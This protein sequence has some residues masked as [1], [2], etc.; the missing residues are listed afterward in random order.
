[1]L[2][3]MLSP[4]AAVAP[5]RVLYLE[6]DTIAAL[7]FIRAFG[8]KVTITAL[9]DPKE[10][11]ENLQRG[12]ETD[13]IVINEN[14]G[15]LAFLD[16]LRANLFLRSIPVILV[17]SYVTDQ[18]KRQAQRRQ[19]LDVLSMDEAEE[20]IRVRIE[21]LIRRREYNFTKHPPVWHATVRL[22]IGKRAFDI[23]VSLG[24]LLFLS[25]LLLLVAILIKL[26]SPGPVL[27]RSK[28]VG[29]GFKVFDMLKFRTMRTDADKMLAGMAAYN[30]Y[31]KAVEQTVGELCDDCRKRGVS[32]QRPLFLDNEQMCEEEYRRR[33]KA[34][35]MFTKFREDPRVTRLGRFLRNSSIDELPQ[36]LNI[37]FGDMSLV[38]NRPL[39]LYEAEK[40]TTTAYVRRFAAPAGLTGLWQVTKR[41]RE[42]QLSDEERIQLDVLY[43]KKFSFKT[44][45]I[46]LIRTLK[47][48]WQKES[49]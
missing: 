47:A 39:P 49:M 23:M 17:S 22:P 32:C 41:G 38:G 9:D 48:L 25:P 37:L 46:I 42:K 28:R 1:M 33:R 30:I 6:R 4:P 8:P 7:A 11:L 35:A 45:L 13:L 18:L 26:D 12:I 24:A 43:A 15:G 44:D 27:Y 2:N 20:A 40:L 19:V 10:A 29:M 31:N 34:K 21:Y 14:L 5:F 36:L 3:V 16:L